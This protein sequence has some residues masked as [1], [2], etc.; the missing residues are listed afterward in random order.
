MSKSYFEKKRERRYGFL[1]SAIIINK[2]KIYQLNYIYK[3]QHLSQ[4]MF[5]A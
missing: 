3:K 2:N 4:L 5:L 1:Q